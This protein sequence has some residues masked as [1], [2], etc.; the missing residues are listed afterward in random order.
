MKDGGPAITGTP[1]KKET[2]LSDSL[3]SACGGFGHLGFFG[4]RR[5]VRS[6]LSKT[7]IGDLPFLAFDIAFS[8]T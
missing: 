1:E 8:H 7:F 3:L 5:P 6:L 2:V 4:C